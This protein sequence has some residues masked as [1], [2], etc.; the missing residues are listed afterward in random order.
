M[1]LDDTPVFHNALRL[2]HTAKLRRTQVC[3]VY[4]EN[5]RFERCMMNAFM[6]FGGV[7]IGLNSSKKS[8]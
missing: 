3:N 6:Y 7:N 2:G 4:C 1:F 5:H 8:Y